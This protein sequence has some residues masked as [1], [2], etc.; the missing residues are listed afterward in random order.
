MNSEIIRVFTIAFFVGFLIF[1]IKYYNNIYEK[2]LSL[3]KW[4]RIV[5]TG[6]ILIL[7]VLTIYSLTKKFITTI[8]VRSE[9][10]RENT[11]YISEFNLGILHPTYIEKI[12]K[13]FQNE[14]S[15][16]GMPTSRIEYSNENKLNVLE[17]TVQ[18]ISFVCK[19]IIARAYFLSNDF[20]SSQ[21]IG[22]QL[23]NELQNISDNQYNNIKN[24]VRKLCYEVHIA[25]MLIE[26]SKYNCDINYIDNEIEEANK[27]L[28]NTYAYYETKS[29]C[30]FLK[31]RDIKKTNDYLGRCKKSIL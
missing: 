2:F 28:K 7:M 9:T 17:F 1:I 6:F 3:K 31:N 18:K 15:I 24:S 10:I 23:F 4:K 30:C 20:N 14:F 16:L 8:K 11:K 13:T 12:E 27:Y 5:I 21:R 29:V 25:K 22:E 26:N 19:Y